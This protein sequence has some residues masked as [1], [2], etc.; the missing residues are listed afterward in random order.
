MNSDELHVLY[1]SGNDFMP[2]TGISIESLFENNKSFNDIFL[3]FFDRGIDNENKEKL[4]TLCTKYGRNIIFYDVNDS[5]FNK[6][7]NEKTLDKINMIT[8]INT[9]SKLLIPSLVPDIDKILYMDADSLVLG[10]LNELWNTNIEEYDFAAAEDLAVSSIF[11]KIK[12]IIGL[13]HKNVYMNAGVMFINL[14]RWKK[15]NVEK[16]FINFLENNESKYM[17]QD[18]FNATLDDI[19]T[20]PLKYNISPAFFEFSYDYFSYYKVKSHYSDKEIN[21]A[22]ENPIIYHFAMSNIVPRPWFKG[23]LFNWGRKLAKKKCIKIKCK[24]FVSI[25]SDHVS[26]SPWKNQVYGKD[27]RT[28]AGKI[29]YLFSH[30]QT[31]SR[32]LVFIYRKTK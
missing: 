1:I 12:N 7:L 27:E 4:E 16:N 21:N 18:V 2:Y 6:M 19:L 22:I 5:K 13:S 14:N 24:D 8:S 31:F 9:L 11:P 28:S 20:I 30:I 15:E 26:K 3:H 10:S 17:D 32:L 25:Y 23:R 29:L